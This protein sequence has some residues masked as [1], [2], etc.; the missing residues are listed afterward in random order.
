MFKFIGGIV[1][2]FM[3]SF[4][5]L[6]GMIIGAVIGSNV[7][8]NI[9]SLLFGSKNRTQSHNNQDA[10]RKFYQQFYE[11]TTR[12]G[13][14]TGYGD[15]NNFGFDNYQSG[16]PDKCY[17]DV[18]CNRTDSNDDIKKHY[19]KVVA[20]YHPDRMAGKGLSDIEMSAAEAR[21]KN[22][23]ESYNQIKKEKGI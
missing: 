2:F 13:Y 9:D 22:I 10:Y 17:S 16:A 14:N 12:K 4:L 7:G 23:Q 5:G 19:R 3:G 11:N 1:G 15:N 6:F 18:G 21:F 20:Q 8:G